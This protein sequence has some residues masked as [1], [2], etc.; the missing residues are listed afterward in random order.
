MLTDFPQRLSSS[1]QCKG[2]VEALRERILSHCMVELNTTTATAAS[3]CS[4]ATA[5]RTLR[6]RRALMLM[7]ALLDE[8]ERSDE[9]NKLRR[10]AHANASQEQ[11]AP[12]LVKVKKNA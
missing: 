11:G 5:T 2:H 3:A 7:F 10:L 4:P 1:L 12:L 9:D 8:S 6:L